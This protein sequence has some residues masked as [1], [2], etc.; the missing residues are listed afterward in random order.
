MKNYIWLCKREVWE[1]RA[2][3]ILP[4]A[5]GALLLL[6]CMF[7]EI[8]FDQLPQTLSQEQLR[9]VAPMLMGGIGSGLFVIMLLYTSWYLLD[10]LYTE[11]KDRSIL[12]WKSLPI[13]DTETVLAKLAMALLVIPLVYF[14]V[15]DVTALGVSFILSVRGGSV[16]TGALWNLRDWLELQVLALYTILTSAL[17][18]LP[19]SGWLLLMSG[20]A[21]KGVTLWALLGPLGA[22]YVEKQLIGTHYL[23][24]VIKMHMVNFASTAYHGDQNFTRSTLIEGDTLRT[25]RVITEFIDPAGFLTS[26]EMWIGVLVGAAFVAG[27][28]YLRHRHTES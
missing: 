2:I 23:W 19:F 9:V 22:A 17:W 3:W 27:A 6:I 8:R 4:V 5:V 20:W 13:T 28:I 1:N 16:V 26:G 21:R 18:Y 11:R 14:V 12:F 24:S 7:G 25:P 15:A 10:C